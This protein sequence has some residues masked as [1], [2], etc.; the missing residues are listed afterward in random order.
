M[1]RVAF[2]LLILSLLSLTGCGT[3]EALRRKVNKQSTVITNLNTAIEQ[4]NFQLEELGKAKKELFQTKIE[5]EHKLK[6]ELS[7]GDLKVQLQERGLIIIVSNNILF[8]PGQVFIK[9][10]AKESLN[11]IAKIINESCSDKLISVEGHTDNRPIRYSAKY[12]SNWELSASRATGVVRYLIKQGVFPQRL[13]A[14]GYGEY[15]PIDTND[16]PQGRANNRRVEIVISLQS[17]PSFVVDLPVE[18]EEGEEK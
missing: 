8:D 4:L 13:S 5:L 10:Q 2:C 11:K 6:K 7:Q 15:H 16:T 17:L 9:P 3:S 14:M 18:P 12:P 1:K